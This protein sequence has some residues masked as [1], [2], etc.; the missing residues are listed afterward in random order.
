MEIS[1]EFIGTV[2]YRAIN[3]TCAVLE[4]MIAQKNGRIINIGSAA[5]RIGDPFQLVYAAAKAAV[6]VFSK[7][8]SQDVGLFGITVNVVSPLDPD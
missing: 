5:G 6:V 7:S 1:D 8:I 3:C 2:E 4:T